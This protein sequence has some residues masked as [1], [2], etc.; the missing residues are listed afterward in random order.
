[1]EGTLEEA[2]GQFNAV[3]LSPKPVQDQDPVT[4][5]KEIR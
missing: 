5:E 3:D 2:S 4:P 1:M